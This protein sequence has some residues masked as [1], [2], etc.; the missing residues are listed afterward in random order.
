MLSEASMTKNVRAQKILDELL[1]EGEVSVEHLSKRLKI[2]SSTVRRELAEL[3]HAGL[4]QRT[5]G[6]A[7]RIEPMLY[8]P[9]R[10]VSSFGAQEQQHTNEKRRIGLAAAEMI[11]DGD[12]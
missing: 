1:R 4:L 5:H 8:E 7:V 11:R 9:F 10:H 2:S 3:E 12:I 6:G